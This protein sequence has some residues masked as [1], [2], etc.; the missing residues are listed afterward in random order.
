MPITFE[1]QL[2]VIKK[3]IPKVQSDEMIMKLILELKKP[4]AK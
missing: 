2:F 3:F 1:K 4:Y